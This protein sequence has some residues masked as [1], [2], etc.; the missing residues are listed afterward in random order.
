MPKSPKHLLIGSTEDYSGKSAVLLGL[1]RQLAAHKIQI[2]YGKPLGTC[3]TET[4]DQDADVRLAMEYL[5]L[6]PENLRPTLLF[7]NHGRVAQRL[8]GT[9][10][11][12]YREQLAAYRQQTSGELV[13]L[14]GPG[15]LEEGRIFGL[16]LRDVAA[17]VEAKVLLVTRYHP[18]QL[19][20]RLLAAQ[21]TLGDRLLGVVIN[22]I[23]ELELDAF[24]TTD[25]AFLESQGISVLGV[26]PHH[27]LLRSVSV[28]E[29]VRQLQAQV[30]CCQERLDLLVEELQIGAMSVNSALKYFRRGNNMAVVTG[31]DRTDIQLAALETSTHCLILTGQLPPDP[32]VLAR[33]EDLEIPILSVDLDTLTTVEIVDRAFGEVR[34]QEFAK[35]Q[36]IQQLMA[37][38]FDLDRLLNALGMNPAAV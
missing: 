10:T 28:Q 30:L 33:A 36:C 14:E 8:T 6:P 4:D 17:T 13:L 18:T 12:D 21:Q 1:A 26:I 15:T 31:G 3:P 2:A 35:I 37:A 22:R 7:L 23:P 24:T 25:R 32:G 34:L 20:D 9:D 19:I 38:H 11:T 29:L 27:A 5:E 16:S